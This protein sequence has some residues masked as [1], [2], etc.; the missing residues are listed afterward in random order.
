[1]QE[2]LTRDEE[3]AMEEMFKEMCGDISRERTRIGGDWAIAGVIQTK[4]HRDMFRSSLVILTSSYLISS[5]HATANEK[6]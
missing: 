1:M 2:K 6:A 4:Q 5:M 3:V